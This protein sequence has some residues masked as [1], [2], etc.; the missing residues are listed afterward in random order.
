MASEEDKTRTGLQVA[1]DPDDGNKNDR[2]KAN[3]AAPANS[4]HNGHGHSM[5]GI[6]LV[7][8]GE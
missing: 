6:I 5:L 8:L 2:Q 4:A 1:E 3:D 7:M